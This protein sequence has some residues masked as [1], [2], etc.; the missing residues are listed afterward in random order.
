M[1]DTPTLDDLVLPSTEAEEWRYSRVGELDLSAYAPTEVALGGS[2]EFVS[3]LADHPEAVTLGGSVI[4]DSGDPFVGLNATFARDALI[5][6]VPPG[7]IVD[8]PIELTH[9]IA[10]AGASFPRV[11]IRAGAD[12]Q[13]TVIERSAADDVQALV[14][15]V[16]EIIVGPAAR[17]RHLGLQDA[18]ERVTQVGRV[19]ATVDQSGTLDLFHVALGGDYARMRFDVALIGRGATGNISA[20]YLASRDQM[21]DLRTF[22]DHL[23][24]DTTSNLLFKGAVDDR[25]RAVYTGLIRI[26]ED[27]RG[28]NANQTNRI[29][30]LSP[31]AWAESVPNL[32]IHQNDVHCSHA[33]AVG[34]IDADQR[35]YLES[36]GV[37]PEAAERLVVNGFFAEVVDALPVPA[38]AEVA[39]RRIAEELA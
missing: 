32:E 15:P 22:Q 12:S 36:R 20:L 27:G 7:R 33:S 37:P 1:T 19:A 21:A 4:D 17:V 26:S 25:A 2:G 8:Q 13:V 23:A 31:D 35:F 6:D 9:L 34:P 16:T 18:G 3:R 39:A 30:K 10:A 38:I 14:V 11:V 28:S 5:I 29:V 24:P